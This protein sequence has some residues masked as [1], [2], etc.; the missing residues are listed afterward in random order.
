[1]ELLDGKKIK[2][3]IANLDRKPG[4]AVIQIGNDPASCVY[5]GN[6]EKTALNLG[7]YF[8]HVKLEENISEEE[9]IS[10]INELN[11]DNEIDGIIVQMPLPKHLNTSKILNSVNK[12]KDIDGLTDINAGLLFHNKDCFIPCTPKG[13]IKIFEHFN[14]PLKGRRV[15]VIGRS[16]IVGKPLAVALMQKGRDAT[17]TV[18]NSSTRDLKSLTLS[19][20]IVI[21]AVG[22]PYFLDASYF[23]HGSVVIDVGINRISDSSR[24]RGYRTVGDVDPSGLEEKEIS[25]TPVPG[26]VGLMTVAELMENTMVSYR[27]R[28]RK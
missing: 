4:I 16:D 2:K 15:L 8:K 9:V 24:K 23:N 7:C 13:I 5:V 20:D 12:D 14:I 17:V 26:G 19:S 22:K 3:E 10:K 18:A 28:I 11:C 25:Y 6:K 1:M 21:S 27:K